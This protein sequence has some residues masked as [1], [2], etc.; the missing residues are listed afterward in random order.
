MVVGALGRNLDRNPVVAQ[1]PGR[2]SA[3]GAGHIDHPGP[4]SGAASLLYGLAVDLLG[5]ALGISI[6]LGLSIIVGSLVPLLLA[7]ALRLKS[8]GGLLPLVS[9]N[10]MRNEVA[11]SGL[12]CGDGDWGDRLCAG[13]WRRNSAEGRTARPHFRIG[14][15][16]AILAGIGG[17]L[18]NVGI[19]YGKDLLEQVGKTTPEQQWV[20]W[21]IF[22]SAAAVTQSGYCLLRTLKSGNARLFVAPRALA[23]AGLVVVMSVVWAASVYFYATS[24][25]ALGKLG[26]SFGWPIFLGLIVVT[27][28][29]WGVLLG[30]WRDRPRSALYRMA[31]GSGILVAAV[32]LIAQ[33]RPM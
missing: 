14:L 6:Q 5:V 20:A 17:P 18:M 33:T 21:A 13:R 8:V 29:V 23:D 4:G 12:A 2:D 16:I 24:A 3:I 32:F 9:A 26:T 11:L 10:A 1:N 31:I 15:I 19:Q 25:A 22:L 30:E 27:S 7:N 28:N